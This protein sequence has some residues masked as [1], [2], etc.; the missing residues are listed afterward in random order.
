MLRSTVVVELIG[1]ASSIILLTTLIRQVYVQWRTRSSRGISRY[2]FAGQM[3]ASVGFA[4]YS[5]LLK[6][7]VFTASNVAILAVAMVG[8]YLYA[9]NCYRTGEPYR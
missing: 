7:W 6:N 1:W 9:R 5:Y 4:V 3:A 2:L 8:E